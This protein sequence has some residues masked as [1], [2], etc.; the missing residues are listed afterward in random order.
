V[1]KLSRIALLAAAASIAAPAMA[2]RLD[3]VIV[4][5]HGEKGYVTVTDPS[6][7]GKTREQVKAELAEARVRYPAGVRVGVFPTPRS[8]VVADGASVRKGA[9]DA[10]RLPVNQ[11]YWN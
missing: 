5:V 3:Q 10:A 1:K 6:V 4:P 2:Y 11:Q 8:D 7:Q 9:Y